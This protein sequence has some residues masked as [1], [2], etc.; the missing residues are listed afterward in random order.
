MIFRA[1][2]ICFLA[3]ILTSC[4]RGESSGSSTVSSEASGGLYRT[5]LDPDE[6]IALAKKRKSYMS[7]IR[8]GDFYSLRNAPEEALSYYLS[9]AEK[10]PDDQVVRKKIAHVYFLL[11][12]WQKAY[13]EYSQVP[14]G[15]LTSDERNELFQALFADP[16]RTD[17]ISEISRYSLGTGALE[18]YQAIDTCYSGIHNCVVSLDA[19]TGSSENVLALKK[20]IKNAKKITDAREYRNLLIAAKLYEQSMY[21]A[22]AVISEEILREF[23][24]YTE[25]KKILA[26]SYFE[27]GQYEDAKKYLLA[28]IEKNP[29]DLQSI[30]R[31]GEIQSA[32][33][34]YV[35]SNLY[36]NNAIIA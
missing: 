32:L 28:Y 27:L 9:V 19:Y 2:F 26:F 21:Q 20:Q 29:N 15:E 36:L 18:W 23:P 4:G 6:R 14:V 12:N 1:V 11:K 16:M 7:G 5:N 34:D 30:V 10:I 25:A 31:M 8:K 3:C 17:R 33:S 13:S 24:D 22:S 35:A